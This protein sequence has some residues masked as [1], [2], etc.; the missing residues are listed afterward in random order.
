MYWETLPNWFWVLFNLFLLTTLGA[1]IFS[2]VKKKLKGLTIVAIAI[3]IIVPIIQ[4]INSIGRVEGMNEFEHLVS[5]LQQGAIWPIFV[6]IGYLFLLVW[7]ALFIFKK[8]V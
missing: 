7:W 2:F 3:T 8:A 6:I 5:H 4:W 1:T